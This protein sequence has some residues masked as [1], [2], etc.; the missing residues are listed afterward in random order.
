MNK[1]KKSGFSLISVILT[2]AFLGF[3][4]IYGFQIGLGYLN[5]NII[6]KAMKLTLQD[7]EKKDNATEKSIRDDVARR[8][9]LDNIDVGERDF[10]VTS[11]GDGFT[12]QVNYTKTIKINNEVSIVMD[13]DLEE[14]SK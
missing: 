7:A 3:F 13:F 6:V 5:K 14:S 11:N 2:L 12:I 10:L 8:I 1:N 4:G 9:S